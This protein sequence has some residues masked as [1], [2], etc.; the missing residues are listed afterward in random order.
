MEISPIT[1]LVT[2][3]RLHRLVCSCC[4]Y[5]STGATLP[6]E[7]EKS[8]YKIFFHRDEWISGSL[9]LSGNYQI[10]KQ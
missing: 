4:N 3:H 10:R 5:T 8:T 7:V 2:S 6:A 9:R 1:P